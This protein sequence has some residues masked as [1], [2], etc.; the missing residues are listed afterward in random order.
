MLV[1]MAANPETLLTKKIVSALQAMG[2]MCIKF[3]A[4]GFTIAGVPDLIVM[5]GGET[6]WL[7]IKTP[8]GSC[9]KIQENRHIQMRRYG[10]KIAVVRSPEEAMEFVSDHCPTNGAMYD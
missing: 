8:T 5:R 4:S 1:G 9:S 2:C 6:V 3:H 10:A 7:E